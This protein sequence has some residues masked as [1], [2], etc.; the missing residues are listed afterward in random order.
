MTGTGNYAELLAKRF[1]IAC[2]R[3]GLNGAE[4]GTRARRELDCG[5][6]RPPSPAGQMQL[7]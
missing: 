5:A 6:F 3:L 2:R 4:R 1:E 7:F